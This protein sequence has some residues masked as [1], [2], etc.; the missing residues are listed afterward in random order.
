VARLYRINLHRRGPRNMWT[1][2]AFANDELMATGYGKTKSEA[3]RGAR[4][5]TRTRRKARTGP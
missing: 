1:A 5:E 3:L 2:D 4:Y